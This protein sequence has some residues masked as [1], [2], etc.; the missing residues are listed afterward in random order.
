MDLFDY[1]RE[2]NQKTESPLASR[3]RPATLEEV[4]GQKHIIG[5]DKLL[6]RAIQADKLSSLIFYGPPGTGK[7]TLAKVIA[8]TTHA[9]FTQINATA[10][11]KKDMEAVVKQAK[12]AQG[13]YGKK[14]ILFIDEIHRFN[15]SQQDY[16]LPF[17]EDGTITLIGATTENPYFEVNGALLDRKSVV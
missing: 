15:K 5:K 12:D 2:Q 4:V 11:G 16:L 9:E 3:L 8:H 1:M 6:Y 10:A 7:T 17:V 14:T 13:M